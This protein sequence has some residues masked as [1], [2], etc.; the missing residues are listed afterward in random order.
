MAQF[1]TLYQTALSSPSPSPKITALVSQNEYFITKRFATQ[2]NYI[3][4]TNWVNNGFRTCSNLPEC[5]DSGVVCCT[6]QFSP[7]VPLN[8]L[9]VLT[10]L[11]EAFNNLGPFQVAGCINS[12]NDNLQKLYDDIKQAEEADDDSSS[13]SD[14]GYDTD[15]SLN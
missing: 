9:T 10:R 4:P 6:I 11:R 5:R 2:I 7:P 15:D 14:S 13:D 1:K 3:E 12:S 8:P